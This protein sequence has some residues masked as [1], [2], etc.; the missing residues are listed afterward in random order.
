MQAVQYDRHGGPEELKVAEVPEPSPGPGQ[1]RIAV[2]AASVNPFDTKIRAGLM[3]GDLPAGVGVDGAGIVDQVGDGVSEVAL[4]L[5][6]FGL[7][8]QTAAEFAVLDTYTTKPVQ[9][10]WV[11]AGASG[12]A[13]EAAHRGL[14]LLGLG[15]GNTVLIDGAA[16]GVGVFAVQIAVARGLQVIGTGSERNHPFLAGL[17]A[18]PVVYGDGLGDRVRE[19][20]GGEVDGVLDVAGK[21]PI[22]ELTGLVSDPAQV[23]SIA[24]FAATD[25]GARVTSSP[26]DGDPRAALEEI[27][28]LYTGGALQIPVQ[29]V[30]PLAE[31][32]EAHRL[33]ETG[34]VRGK[35]VIT[36]P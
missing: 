4:G 5:E 16:G 22:S 6:V 29:A 8:Q 11:E 3:G 21:S 23:V 35:L 36:V 10:T 9:M 14:G 17:G 18:T 15:S 30:F 2:Q 7:G 28:T 32:A 24:N 34:H 26:A 1:V 20:V 27:S 12:T 25:A 19:I 13:G 31:A 33:S